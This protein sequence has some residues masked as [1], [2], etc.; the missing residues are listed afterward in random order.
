[1]DYYQTLGVEKSASAD[2]IKSAYRKAALKHHPDRNKDHKKESEEQ[3][4]KINEA[5]TVL[6]DPEKRQQYDAF[7]TVSSRPGA[8]NDP[9]TDIFES[10]FGGGRHHSGGQDMKIQCSITLEEVASGAEKQISYRRNKVCNSCKGL[11]GSGPICDNCKGHGQVGFRQGFMTTTM[12]CP[13]CSGRGHKINQKCKEC[14]GQGNIQESRTIS[15]KVPIGVEDGHAVKFAGGGGQNRA[16]MSYGDLYCCFRIVPHQRFTRA[17][18]DLYCQVKITML[19][20]CLG[21][22]IQVV[23]LT[24]G[25]EVQL[26]I[27]PGTQ[28]DNTF[29]IKGHGIKHGNF[30]VK[31]A[32]E[33]PKKL[34]EKAMKLLKEVDKELSREQNSCDD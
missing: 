2:E 6:S 12:S 28:P 1:M 27:P 20:A 31:V 33:I 11:G 24:P 34:S 29:N 21:D 15:V 22:T 4:K 23:L 14:D 18:N 5:Y 7:G 10:F 13:N 32:V 17:G 19:Q 26:K 30:F 9:F 25:K 8:V 16:G 3:F